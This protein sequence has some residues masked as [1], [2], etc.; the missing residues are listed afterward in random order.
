MEK[1]GGRVPATMEELVELP[2]VGR[3]TANVVLGNAMGIN[4]G[5]VVDTHVGRVSGRLGF[6]ESADP[7]VIEQDLMK[8]IPREKWTAFAHRVIYHGRQT[9]EARKPKCEECV[10][11][12]LCPS[13]SEFTPREDAGSVEQPRKSSRKAASAKSKPNSSRMR[14]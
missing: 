14:H 5:V 8:L 6:T 10:V 13:V 1:H 9:C 2:G 3:K 12:D 7:V 4:V 11:N